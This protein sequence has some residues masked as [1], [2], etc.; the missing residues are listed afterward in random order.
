[1]SINNAITQRTFYLPTIIV[2]LNV[3]HKP[4]NISLLNHPRTLQTNMQSCSTNSAPCLTSLTR[5]ENQCPHL[6]LKP[7]LH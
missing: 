5:A 7:R 6:T 3:K 1:M 4:L 2:T